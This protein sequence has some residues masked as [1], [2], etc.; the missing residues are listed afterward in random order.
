MHYLTSLSSAS[1]R[2]CSSTSRVAMA[3][4][5]SGCLGYK[6]Y[7]FVCNVPRFLLSSSGSVKTGNLLCSWYQ[8]CTQWCNQKLTY[9]VQ[10]FQFGRGI[11]TSS[12]TDIRMAGNKLQFETWS[13]I[14]MRENVHKPIR[15][16]ELRALSD[17]EFSLLIRHLCHSILE[18]LLGPVHFCSWI[19]RHIHG[20]RRQ[21]YGTHSLTHSL[22]RF[23]LIYSLKLN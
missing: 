2:E 7:I 4:S 5:W 23:W 11:S 10:S 17:P 19:W 15:L 9:A 1:R 21:S 16:L 3:F 6:L 13:H 12:S 14:S 8:A 18:S 20:L 22:T